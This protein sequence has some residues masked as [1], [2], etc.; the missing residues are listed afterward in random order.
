MG[1]KH[2]PNHFRTPLRD[3]QYKPESI[4]DAPHLRL[5][6]ENPNSHPS[7]SGTFH[8][9]SQLAPELRA[10]IW[11][12]AFQRQHII[13]VFLAAGLVRPMN[14][15]MEWTLVIDYSGWTQS[16]ELYVVFIHGRQL[17]NKFLQVCRESRAEVLRVYRVQI[18]C[19]IIINPEGRKPVQNL[20]ASRSA[21]LFFSP[22][23]DFLHIAGA[24]GPLSH[25]IFVDFI[26]RLK[27]E[28]DPRNVGLL[29]LVLSRND[30]ATAFSDNDESSRSML[31]QHLK[32]P[33][34][35]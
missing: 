33:F 8:Q 4:L 26:T 31:Q 25:Q 16:E 34:R 20:A 2:N 11:Q 22:E 32:K 35:S 27:T 5:I 13:R 6:N 29:N 12:Y 30:I 21:T 23:H 9:F 7:N 3:F 17:F 18:P 19:H 14:G 10:K 24:R 28:H 15:K 1:L